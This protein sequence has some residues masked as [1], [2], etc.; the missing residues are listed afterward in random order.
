MP[1]RR[2]L[3]KFI[4]LSGLVSILGKRG[5]Y[6]TIYKQ[7]TTS[8]KPHPPL[9]ASGDLERVAAL[10]IAAGVSALPGALRARVIHQLSRI[11]GTIWHRTNRGTV[12]RVRHHLQV[13]FDYQ[14]GPT[15]ESLVYSQL[16]LASWNAFI[17][18]MLP[19]LRT[20]YVTHLC[21]IEGLHQV[22]ETRRQNKPI[23]LL[24]AHYGIYG[25]LIV[26]ALSARGHPTRLTG[27]GNYCSDPPRTSYLYRKLYWPQLQRV[28]RWVNII[29]INPGT[30]LQPELFKIL[31][32]KDDIVYL[33]PDQYFTVCPDQDH[34]S[35]LVPLR[36]LNHTVY[37]DVTGVQLAKRMGVQPLTAIP[38]KDGCGQRILIEP[39]TWAGSGTATADIAQDMQIYL[40]RLEG[41]LLEYPALWRDLQRLDLLPRM[42]IFEGEESAGG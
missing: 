23:L 42:G 3:S 38:I 27:Y 18:N 28:G 4:G 7:V 26:T 29:T 35:H 13:L 2:S 24:G 34:P 1:G 16:V 20:E 30:K 33:L 25:Y 41:R 32:Q 12:H 14:T 9:I 37:L 5:S 40:T 39:L 22:N 17:A 36:L 10:V 8:E 31:K 21:Q 19:S 11:A 15:L 6:M